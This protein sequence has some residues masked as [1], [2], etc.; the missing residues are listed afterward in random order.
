MKYRIVRFI[1]VHYRTVHVL[2]TAGQAAAPR[3]FISILY[4]VA[5]NITYSNRIY[6]GYKR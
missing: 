5:A 6:D 2:Y 1:E 3:R 4:F